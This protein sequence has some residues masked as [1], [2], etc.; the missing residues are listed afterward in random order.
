MEMKFASQHEGKKE[1]S[2]VMSPKSQH[3]FSPDNR[4]HLVMYIWWTHRSGKDWSNEERWLRKRVYL[5]VLFFYFPFF[6][7]GAYVLM[8]FGVEDHWAARISF[9]TSFLITLPVSRWL[10]GLLWPEKVCKAEEN[11][12][13]RYGYRPIRW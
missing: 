8:W 12:G 1:T 2:T 4:T 11:A 3:P 9:V 5:I 6:I 7:P 13:R 10:C